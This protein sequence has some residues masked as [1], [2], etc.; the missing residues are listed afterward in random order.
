MSDAPTLTLDYS[1]QGRRPSVSQIMSAWRKAKC[2]AHFA[3]VYGETYAEFQRYDL[4]WHDSG[5]GAR[6]VDRGAVVRALTASLD[7]A[8]I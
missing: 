7:K 5:N 2:P 4:R 8:R 1:A 6:G 3:V